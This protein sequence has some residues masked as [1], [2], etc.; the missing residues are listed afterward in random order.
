MFPA[1]Y[2]LSDE[3]FASLPQEPQVCAVA[4]PQIFPA[5]QSAEVS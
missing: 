1:P 4:T 3:Q 5:V 2:R